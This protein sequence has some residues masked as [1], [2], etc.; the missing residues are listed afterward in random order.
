MATLVERLELLITSSA[1]GAVAGLKETEAASSS[2]DTKAKGLTGTLQRMGISGQV[3]GSIMT[4]GI[5]GGA[6]AAGAA[7]GKFALDGISHF[8]SLTAEVRAYQ[9]V[10]G[11]SAEDSSRVAAAIRIM[12][13]DSET[14][15]KGF[16]QLGKRIG[17]GTDT[18]GQYGAAIARNQDGT[19]NMSKTLENAAV[20]YQG[21]GDATVR[22][23]FLFENFGRSGSALIPILSRSRSD[24][25]AI[26]AEADRNHEIFSQADLDKGREYQEAM[27]ELHAAVT[28]LQVSIGSQLIPMLTGLAVVLTDAVQFMNNF[29][30][31][32]DNV[33]KKI[34]PSGGFFGKWSDSLSGVGKS[35][36]L[37]GAILGEFGHT[38]DKVKEAQDRLTEAE[39]KLQEVT[40]SNTSTAK[41]RNAAQ[42]EY[43]DASAALAAMQ[44]KLAN[45]TNNATGA[46]VQTTGASKAAA[47][48]RKDE[49]DASKAAADA[50]MSFYD[51]TLALSNSQLG[52]EGATLNVE[53][54]LKSYTDAVNQNGASSLEARQAHVSLEESIN[55]VATQALE[56]YK[57]QITL[58][59][60][61]ETAYGKAQAQI[62]ALQELDRQFPGLHDSIQAHIDV[63]GRIPPTATTNITLNGIEY[64]SARAADYANQLNNLPRE[65]R[66]QI[67]ADLYST[68]PSGLHLQHGGPIPGGPSMA[69]PV[70][71]HGG[72]Y[73]LSQDV[74][75]RIKSGRPSRGANVLGGSSALEPR[76]GDVT[77]AGPQVI[78]LIVGSRVL[79]EVM[80]EE[81]GRSGG[82]Q[83]P[84][85]AIA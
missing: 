29:G 64:Y 16:F 72:E 32:I 47:Q 18:L 49:A 5:V 44:D 13:I 52:M 77:V 85:R 17:E 59:G 82:P 67:F 73:V 7:V 11:G 37:G 21:I 15:Q 20:A 30:A 56:G 75:S 78:Q 58:A 6:V 76:G 55:A 4:A 3:A 61:T 83:M 26:Y 19:V 84:A 38:S 71:A 1:K 9:R 74:V 63:L 65:I 50:A 80:V 40:L 70:I 43:H 81:F 2:L 54:A 41:E 57:A 62:G 22:D 53:A 51:A 23:A 48:A 10:L 8:A 14:A 46:T 36:F 34:D 45:A 27:R 25:E 33:Q 24:I 35:L 39:K 69:V 79:A 12:G 60:G 68:V 28:G 66:T 31:S 42:R